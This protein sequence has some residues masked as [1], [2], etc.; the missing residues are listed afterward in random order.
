MFL[1]FLEA[2]SRSSTQVASP[3]FSKSLLKKL[4][5]WWAAQALICATEILSSSFSA[6][7]ELK[8]DKLSV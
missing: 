5:L 6:E 2:F 4:V 1:P 7:A 8:N 3:F